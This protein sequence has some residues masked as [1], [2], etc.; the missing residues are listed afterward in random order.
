LGRASKSQTKQAALDELM[1]EGMDFDAAVDLIKEAAALEGEY[2]PAGGGRVA[3]IAD[4][5]MMSKLKGILGTRAGKI[6]GAVAALGAAA[7]LGRA[8]KS[9]TKQAALDELMAE[10]VSFEDAV[11]L[12]KEASV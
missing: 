4:P 9:Q 1:A 5:S 8:S 12:I 2:I 3:K 7:A 6:G 10:G 11:D